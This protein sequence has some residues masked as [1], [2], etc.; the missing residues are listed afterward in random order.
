M[1]SG[2][3]ITFEGIDGCGKTT[4]SERALEHLKRRNVDCRL[5]REPGGTPVGEAIRKVLL[6]SAEKGLAMDGY[7]EYLL[8]AASRAELCRNVVKPSLESGCTV[9]LDRFG[10]SSTAYQGYGRGVDI[11]FIVR[12]N[13]QS[14]G[15]LKPDLSILFDIDP[16]V[17]MARLGSHRDRIEGRGLDFFTSVRDGFLAI[18]HAEPERFRVVDATKSIEAVSS[19]VVEIIDRII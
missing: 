8:F 9:L 7:T 14:S 10:D 12:T 2:K 15:G 13:L 4:Q 17:A 11:N 3:M 1:P 16:T 19:E 5:L 18:A 6:A